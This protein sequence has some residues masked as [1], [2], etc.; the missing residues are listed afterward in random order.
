MPQNHCQRGNMAEKASGAVE[1]PVQDE[2][3]SPKQ[4]EMAPKN[5]PELEKNITQLKTDMK[6]VGLS[7]SKAEEGFYRVSIFVW[8]QWQQNIAV[9]PSHFCNLQATLGFMSPGYSPCCGHNFN[10][11][12]QH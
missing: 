5:T 1:M 9:D 4:P 11:M 6:K 7:N 2:K 3:T 8:L 12:P 10:T